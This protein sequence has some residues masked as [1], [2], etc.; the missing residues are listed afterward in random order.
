VYALCATLYAIMRG[1]PPRW[2]DDRNPSLITLMDLFAQEVPDLPGVPPALLDLL[3]RGMVNDPAA[4]PSAEELRDLLA[5]VAIEPAQQGGNRPPAAPVSGGGTIYGARAPSYPV[6]GAPTSGGPTP[7]GVYV[8]R[9]Y[10]PP[11]PPQPPT[12]PPPDVDSNPTEPANPRRRKLRWWLGG[13]GGIVVIAVAVA[14]TWY[15]TGRGDDPDATGRAAPSP[16]VVIGRALP[17]CLLPLPAGGRCPDDVECFGPVASSGSARRL[18]CTG[19]HTWETYAEGDLP[20]SVT[21]V[22]RDSVKAAPAVRQVCAETSFT[23]VTL[24]MSAEG[25]QFDVL[26][27]DADALAA[28]D[29][30]YRCLA[31]KGTDQLTG[32]TLAR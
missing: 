21:A 14:A 7:Q 13:L 27:P 5:A 30:T 26:P 6:S 32:P 18:P 29:R 25:W 12:P 23:A 28:G 20:A 11:T 16:T 4:R 8:S 2:S 24:L 22:D 9:S 19:R 3:R 1:K 31:G 15:A 17:G 10:A